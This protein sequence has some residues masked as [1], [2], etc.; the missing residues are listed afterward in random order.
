MD[1][2]SRVAGEVDGLRVSAELLPQIVKGDVLVV[3]A[4]DHDGLCAHGVQARDGA[5]GA[6]G[7]G[8]VDIGHAA[9]D[10]HGLEPVLDPGKTPRHIGADPVVR[11][12]LHR[13]EGREVVEHVVLPGQTDLRGGQHRA[14]LP[15]ADAAE[16][17][18]SQKRA[19][20]HRLLI[21]KIGDPGLRRSGVVGR[22]SVVQ[23]QDQ[24]V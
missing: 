21:R 17:A 20:F 22:V 7:D 19:V 5:G 12:A 11:H 23:V 3:A 15:A 18:V 4:R 1:H 6:G 16:D 14:H 10:A 13:G 2:R 8:V 24:A 9:Q